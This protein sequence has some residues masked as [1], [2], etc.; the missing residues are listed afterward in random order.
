MNVI[1][2]VNGYCILID[3]IVDSGGTLVNAAEALIAQRRQGSLRLRH[4]RRAVGWRRRPDRLL[5]A[6]RARHHRLDPADRSGKQGAEHPLLVIA[7]LIAEAISRTASEDR[8]RACSTEAVI[9]SD[10][11]HLV[12]WVERSDTHQGCP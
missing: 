2:E 1:G 11:I 6:Q 8:C 10:A 4:P 5:E 7:P 12:G 3:D 9:V